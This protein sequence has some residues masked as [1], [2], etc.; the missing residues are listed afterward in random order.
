MMTSVSSGH[1]INLM[2]EQKLS[3]F[4]H[5]STRVFFMGWPTFGTIL[6]TKDTI[7][8]IYII[9]D[10]QND[11]AFCVSKCIQPFIFLMNEFIHWG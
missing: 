7:L 9:L 1:F 5:V 11:N 3:H 6:N 10:T 2:N 8:C 4:G